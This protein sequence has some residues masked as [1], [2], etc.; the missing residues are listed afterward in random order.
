V[1]IDAHQ[2]ALMH[3]NAHQCAHANDN[4]NIMQKVILSSFARHNPH[5][6]AA[7]QLA[8]YPKESCVFVVDTHQSGG[9]HVDISVADPQDTRLSYSLQY[10]IELKLPLGNLTT[11]DQCIVVKFL[12]ISTMSMRNNPTGGNSPVF[13]QTSTTLGSS[14]HDTRDTVIV[15]RQLT[16]SLADA[17]VYVDGLSQEQLP[18]C[19]PAVRQSRVHC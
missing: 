12:T 10:F 16:Q 11:T 19:A 8:F 6:I 2:C 3:T 1:H 14:L 15:S 18:Q 9:F 13:C 5:I 7:I 17:I 4:S